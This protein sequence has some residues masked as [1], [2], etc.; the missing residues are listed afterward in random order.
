M[1]KFRCKEAFTVEMCDG[2]GFTIP[3]HEM[4]IEVGS[5]WEGNTNELARGSMRLETYEPNGYRWI[6]GIDELTL[7]E[8]FEEIKE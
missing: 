4:Q 6:D 2:D 7:K 5:T 1:S 3:E 8:C